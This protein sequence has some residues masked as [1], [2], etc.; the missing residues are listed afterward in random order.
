MFRIDFVINIMIFDCVSEERPSLE[1]KERHVD[2]MMFE[3]DV[4]PSVMVE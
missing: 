2:M 4:R 1:Q 3:E